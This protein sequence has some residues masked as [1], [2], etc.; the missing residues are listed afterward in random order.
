[1]VETISSRYKENK[2]HVWLVKAMI[3]IIREIRKADNSC[4][5]VVLL[6]ALCSCSPLSP[7]AV[8]QMS[9]QIRHCMCSFVL[10]GFR[11]LLGY[12]SQNLSTQMRK[13]C[14]TVSSVNDSGFFSFHSCTTY[15]A[16]SCGSRDLPSLSE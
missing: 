6:F 8:W 10:C 4:W 14:S 1:M 7:E 2:F 5:F 11:Y 12:L 9:V 16:S 13:G 15:L 3:R